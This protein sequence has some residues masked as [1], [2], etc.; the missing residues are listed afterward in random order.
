MRPY[1]A[2]TSA[3]TTRDAARGYRPHRQLPAAGHAELPDHEHVQWRAERVRHLERHRDAASRQRQDHDVAAALEV[4]QAR[5]QLS[6]GM[7]PIPVD[8]G[9]HR[10]RSHHDAALARATAASLT[11]P[12]AAPRPDRPHQR[13]H[14][15]RGAHQ[16]QAS[17]AAPH[18]DGQ[19]DQ[20]SQPG[21]IDLCHAAHVECQHAPGRGVDDRAASRAQ[22]MHG[23]RIRRPVTADPQ[24][25]GVT[26][27]A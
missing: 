4:R 26:L 21:R 23:S 15:R 14:A 18:L 27:A 3:L 1:H 25:R 13:A 19:H 2:T 9:L 6:S 12:S 5:R 22:L 17:V 7:P 10:P 11:R 24:Q 16:P 8:A 20:Q